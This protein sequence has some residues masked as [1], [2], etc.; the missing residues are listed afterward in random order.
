MGSPSS[1][2]APGL[3]L[4]LGRHHDLAVGMNRVPQSV[5]A[6]C[7]SLCRLSDAELGELAR[8]RD[9][10]LALAG[11]PRQLASAEG[12]AA[13]ASQPGRSWLARLRRVAGT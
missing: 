1:T 11:E 5:T 2:A 4:R 13:L 3:D 7:D 12:V 10:E 6:F 8:C 9:P